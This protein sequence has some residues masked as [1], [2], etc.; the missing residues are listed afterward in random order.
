MGKLD[1]GIHAD[2]GNAMHWPY[3]PAPDNQLIFRR[4][5]KDKTTITD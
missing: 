4:A 5:L 3:T 2:S 1:L